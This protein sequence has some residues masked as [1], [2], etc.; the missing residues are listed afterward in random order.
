MKPPKSPGSREYEE[1]E[2][3][4]LAKLQPDA[5]R[6]TLAFAGLYQLAHE[7]LKKAILEDVRG[8]YAFGVDDAGPILDKRMY[9]QHVLEPGR[10]PGRPRLNEFRACVA[11][12]VRSGALRQGQADRLDQIYDHRHELTHDLGQFLIDVDREPDVTLFTD[13]LEILKSIHRFWV[14]VEADIGTFDE[15]PADELDLD[16][17]TPLSLALLQIC[18]DGYVSGLQPDTKSQ[19]KK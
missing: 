8:F 1:T 19:A 15:I 2:R 13:A 5:V 16:A 4:L 14:Q 17:V 12:L 11:W 18:I 7:M 9:E 6:S 3:R 10:I